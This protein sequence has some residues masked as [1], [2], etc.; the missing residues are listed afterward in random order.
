MLVGGAVTAFFTSA[1]YDDDFR[2][3]GREICGQG[4]RTCPNES[5]EP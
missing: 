5:R 3:D 1:I 2:S 4:R